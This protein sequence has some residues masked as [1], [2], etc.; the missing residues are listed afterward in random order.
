MISM[1]D[2]QFGELLDLLKELEVDENT[3]V[4]FS[5]DNGGS[6]HPDV[7]KTLN[8]GGQLQGHKRS[9]YEGGIRTPFLVRW[10]GHTKPDTTTDFVVSHQDLFPTLAEIG[11]ASEHVPEEVTGLSFVELLEGGVPARR[12]YW[13]YWEWEL[14]DW[15][16]NAPRPNG[17]MQAMRQGH[18][19]LLRHRSDQPWEL[20][21]LPED[22][23]EENNLAA[24]YPDKVEA[25]SRLIETAR[26][27][28]R[29]Q[30]EP[31]M[32]VGRKY[33]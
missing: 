18:W 20:Y 11:G 12:H 22:W 28:M 19:K 33:R 29:P 8:P 2:R 23:G 21:F 32:P 24:R 4:I 13:H 9:M 26:V 6:E 25:L 10:P 7:I 1:I 27:P 31:E 3:L 15:E 14:W 17:L 16:K 5:S 30:Q